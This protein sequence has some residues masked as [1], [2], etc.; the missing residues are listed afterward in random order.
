MGCHSSKAAAPKQTPKKRAS[1]KKRASRTLLEGPQGKPKSAIEDLILTHTEEANSDEHSTE[2]AKSLEMIQNTITEGAPLFNAGDQ[3]GCYKLYLECAQ[4]LLSDSNLLSWASEEAVRLLRDALQESQQASSPGEQA[5]ALRPALDHLMREASGLRTA[6]LP[7]MVNGTVVMVAE[8][9]GAWR[10]TNNIHAHPESKIAFRATKSLEDRLEAFVDFGQLIEGTDQG[11][12]W[13]CCQISLKLTED[14]AAADKEIAAAEKAAANLAAAE[15]GAAG[16]DTAD[17]AAAEKAVAPTAE[18]ADVQVAPTSRVQE[19]ITLYNGTSLHG[20]ETLLAETKQVSAAQEDPLE[21]SL[22]P[23]F[24]R[25]VDL[26]GEHR[27]EVTNE[28]DSSA[29]QAASQ[30]LLVPTLECNEACNADGAIGAVEI[31]S[32]TQRRERSAFC[33]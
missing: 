14:K 30:A 18:P 21:A 31:R 33:C 26:A 16:I 29:M 25:S 5:W 4:R 24:L 2:P 7:M 11:D 3:M 15:S 20:K 28:A 19:L 17:E 27:E 12:G 32:V 23:V 1:S 10:V 6:Y 9:M 8:G 22:S 13:L